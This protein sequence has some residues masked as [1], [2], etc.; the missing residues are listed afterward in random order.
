M[1]NEGRRVGGLKGKSAGKEEQQ[2]LERPR[3]FLPL[4]PQFCPLQLFC[5]STL[6]SVFLFE[7]A[8]LGW[9]QLCIIGHYLPDRV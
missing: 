7:S 3:V 6:R 1:G 2:A 8:L 5:G 4:T 9:T